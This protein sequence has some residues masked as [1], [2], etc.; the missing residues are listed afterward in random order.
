MDGRDMR[1]H[2]DH[3]VAQ[4]V[5]SF[6]RLSGS[7]PGLCEERAQVNEQNRDGA[8]LCSDSDQFSRD[9]LSTSDKLNI[10]GTSS[11]RGFL[12]YPSP[13][14]GADDGACKRSGNDVNIGGREGS[15]LVNFSQGQEEEQA[16]QAPENARELTL[17]ISD[18][19]SAPKSPSSY[20]GRYETASAQY[21][22][23]QPASRDVD[24]H[25]HTLSPMIETTAP[26][27]TCKRD[28]ATG[29]EF[30]R[31]DTVGSS[32]SLRSRSQSAENTPIL[33]PPSAPRTSSFIYSSNE[34][35]ETAE[36][37]QS[38]ICVTTTAPSSDNEHIAKTPPCKVS[39]Q[40]G[41]ISLEAATRTAQGAGS[42]SLSVVSSS[43]VEN[44]IGV[45]S[46]PPM[47]RSEPTLAS[48]V[49]LGAEAKAQS[50]PPSSPMKLSSPPSLKPA[51]KI[52]RIHTTSLGAPF[53][54]PRSGPIRCVLPTTMSPLPPSSPP[55]ML[56]SSPPT[57]R[58]RVDS[59]TEDQPRPK[60]RRTGQ[61]VSSPFVSPLRNAQGV[62]ARPPAGGFSTPLRPSTIRYDNFSS[63]I[64]PSQPDVFTTPATAARSSPAYRSSAAESSPGI[65]AS[66]STSYKLR[67]PRTV[68]RPFKPPTKSNRPTTATVQA[69]RQRLQLLRNALRI[70]GLADPTRPAGPTQPVKTACS[71]E[72]LE[73]LALRWRAAAQ[74]AA[75]DLWALVRD[76]IGADSWGSD[77]GGSNKPDA[78]GW[79]DRPQHVPT[80]LDNANTGKQG[81]DD[82]GSSD[83]FT[84]PPVNKVHQSLFK[85]LNRP[86]VP[87]KTLLSPNKIDTP[88]FVS[89]E[90]EERMGDTEPEEDQPKY[91]TLGTMLTSL[92]IPYQVLGWQEEEG[93]FAN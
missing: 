20:V 51:Q 32:H 70:R 45:S 83:M 41:S 4:Q 17:V 1:I 26:R 43:L 2:S 89:S 35:D 82:V 66:T 3:Q 9:E 62:R 58:P 18:F 79:S 28:S 14:E 11:L 12:R 75:Q 50:T 48:P 24:T 88:A 44:E 52:N 37:P 56:P 7:Q 22:G 54:N 93:E 13:F 80:R 85:N 73:V 33:I 27:A 90:T 67:P 23:D 81:L 38:A 55:P 64:L 49:R 15:V 25:C 72:E 77:S 31:Q 34:R 39:L 61:L 5:G 57:K 63:P 40:T 60:V 16:T 87:R 76:S 36:V 59:D 69:L 21:Q 19:V 78:W 86:C 29:K 6:Q 74:E 84:P 30:V 53:R 65:F 92:G 71:D 91:H 47:P 68:T 46:T 8:P 10:G 42:S